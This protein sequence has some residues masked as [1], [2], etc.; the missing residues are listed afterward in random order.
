MRLYMCRCVR[1]FFIHWIVPQNSSISIYDPFNVLAAV[2][3]ILNDI[4]EQVITQCFWIK[5]LIAANSSVDENT[6]LKPPRDALNFERINNVYCT[7]TA[8]FCLLLYILFVH[9]ICLFITLFAWW[10]Q[11]NQS[12]IYKWS[13]RMK[14][15][16]KFFPSETSGKYSKV[17]SKTGFFMP[18][19]L[20]SE[21]YQVVAVV[22]IKFQ[23]SRYDCWERAVI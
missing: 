2:H 6:Q 8:L 11:W 4:K 1:I 7:Q 15:S 14:N 18:S 13:N 23:H 17:Y 22:L 3:W 5:P 9:F 21:I 12:L 19:S 20:T 16:E 10:N